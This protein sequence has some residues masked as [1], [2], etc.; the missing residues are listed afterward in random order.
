MNFELYCVIQVFQVTAVYT[1][2]RCPGK[3]KDCPV[4]VQGQG[5]TDTDSLSMLQSDEF[6]TTNLRVRPLGFCP[7][8]QPAG[9]WHIRKGIRGS[10]KQQEFTW[11]LPA[12]VPGHPETRWNLFLVRSAEAGNTDEAV[13][14]LGFASERFREYVSVWRRGGKKHV[15]IWT[16]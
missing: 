7:I 3:W 11:K 9:L 1:R 8:L 6:R 16:Q 5:Q 10:G 15:W 4:Q 12:V 13:R 2:T 14:C